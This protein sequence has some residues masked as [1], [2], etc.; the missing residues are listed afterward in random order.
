MS[1]SRGRKIFLLL[2]FGCVFTACKLS[3][4]ASLLL[5]KI[6]LLGLVTS[7]REEKVLEDRPFKELVVNFFKL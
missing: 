7:T 6:V 5:C 4:P 1:G 3:A 2:G